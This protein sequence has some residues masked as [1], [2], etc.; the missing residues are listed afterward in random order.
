MRDPCVYVVFWAPIKAKP[1][2]SKRWAP[3]RAGDALQALNILKAE[4]AE[5]PGVEVYL[6]Y[7]MLQL[8]GE[9][10]T[11]LSVILEVPKVPS[12]SSDATLLWVCYSF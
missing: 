10:G 8:C 2:L 12:G 11:I 6:S 1:S 9:Y 3:G 4:A 7:T 5:R